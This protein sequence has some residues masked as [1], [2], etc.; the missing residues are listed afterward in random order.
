M[1]T[2]VL[3]HYGK[4]RRTAHCAQAKPK[5]PRQRPG[6]R[7]S[8]RLAARTWRQHRPRQTASWARPRHFVRQQH[9]AAPPTPTQAQPCT[10]HESKLRVCR[11]GC[12]GEFRYVCAPLACVTNVPSRR[13]I[14]EARRRP[15]KH[16]LDT[17]CKCTRL[18][19]GRCEFI[20]QA[21]LRR[22]A[23]GRHHVDHPTLARNGVPCE[24][25][26]TDLAGTLRATVWHPGIQRHT[27][28]HP[29]RRSHG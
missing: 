29:P 10:P 24:R 26:A 7:L 13:E 16:G 27:L 20:H 21:L 6:A 4:F 2:Y 25:P 11:E 8:Q 12:R 5:R 3:S 15:G 14:W 1:S 23:G 22:S 19:H 9:D 17:S 28:P 18:Q